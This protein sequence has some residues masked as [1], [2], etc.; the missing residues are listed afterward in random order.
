MATS[1]DGLQQGSDGVASVLTGLV[2]YGVTA[3]GNMKQPTQSIS[4][5]EGS[6]ALSG[7]ARRLQQ[8]SSM[9]GIILTHAIGVP[10]MKVCQSLSQS[11]ERSLVD[12]KQ[13]IVQE[14]DRK[15]H[16]SVKHV[17]ALPSTWQQKAKATVE[18]KVQN[19]LQTIA[20]IPT[21]A[22]LVVQQAIVQSMPV[23]LGR[24]M[25]KCF[26]SDVKGLFGK[27]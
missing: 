9:L 11:V 25:I 12:T 7:S 6:I 2:A 23:R 17:L 8:V 4:Q 20:T 13:S 27:Q 3:V 22:P 21:K 10:T 5:P 26:V 18:E 24:A 15:I 19:T 16:E 14:A 1:G